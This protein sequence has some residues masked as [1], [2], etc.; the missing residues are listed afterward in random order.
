M[1]IGGALGLSNFDD[2]DGGDPTGG[3]T[4]R[5][6][7]RPVRSFA[8]EAQ[9]DYFVKFEEGNARP[10]LA[11]ANGRWMIPQGWLIPRSINEEGRWQ[12]F[13]LG[14][15]GWMQG[16]QTE[17]GKFDKLDSAVF[18]AGLGIEY[19]PTLDVAWR[20]DAQYM[21]PVGDAS[22]LQF[23]ALLITLQLY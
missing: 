21:I 23:A 4:F 8:V 6:G 9:A 7:I 20:I 14:G 22:D 15:A 19:Y 11:T 3:P 17:N 18:R 13:L 12:P 5:V 2:Y 16:R 1:G 10:I